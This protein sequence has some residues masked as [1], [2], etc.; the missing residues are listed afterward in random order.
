MGLS[1]FP[2]LTCIDEDSEEDVKP[3][4]Y[5][6]CPKCGSNQIDQTS[7]E[8]LCNAEWYHCAQCGTWYNDEGEIDVD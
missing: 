8:D 1:D 6:N 7:S 5:A 2:E 3:N 4:P